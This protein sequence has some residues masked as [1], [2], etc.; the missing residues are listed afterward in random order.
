MCCIAEGRN[1]VEWKRGEGCVVH[2]KAYIASRNKECIVIV[3][4]YYNKK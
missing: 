3:G 4:M 2:P 1:I